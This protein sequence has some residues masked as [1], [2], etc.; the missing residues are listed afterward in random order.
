MVLKNYTNKNEVLKGENIMGYRDDYYDNMFAREREK[1][2]KI[3]NNIIKEFEK[4]S[5]E[6]KVDMLIAI[7]AEKEACGY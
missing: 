4:L 7:Y 3:Y 2:E 1:R 6:E 5:L